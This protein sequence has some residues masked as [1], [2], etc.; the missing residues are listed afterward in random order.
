MKMGILALLF[1]MVNSV[2]KIQQ[3]HFI[4]YDIQDAVQGITV[5]NANST[6]EIHGTQLRLSSVK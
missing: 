5:Y 6:T 4:F 3:T 2:E 1:Q